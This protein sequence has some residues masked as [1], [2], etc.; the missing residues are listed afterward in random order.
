MAI[1]SS[2]QHS[3]DEKQRH[4]M[5]SRERSWSEDVDIIE[6]NYVGIHNN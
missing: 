5:R 4:E 2:N 3:K 6:I 1:V